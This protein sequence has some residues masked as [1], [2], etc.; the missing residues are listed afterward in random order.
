VGTVLL[1]KRQILRETRRPSWKIATER[2]IEHYVFA[3]KEAQ[4][5]DLI[6]HWET[7]QVRRAHQPT[8]VQGSTLQM[9]KTERTC[10]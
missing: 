9:A 10:L 1:L 7:D 3:A 6:R 8:F 4:E 5:A 2:V